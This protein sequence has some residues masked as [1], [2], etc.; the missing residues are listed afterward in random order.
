MALFR[1]VASGAG[2]QCQVR[3]VAAGL[4]AVFCCIETS[5]G[6]SMARLFDTEL[7]RAE[8]NIY[9][10][11]RRPRQMLQ[12]QTYDGHVSIHDESQARELGFSGAPIEGRSAPV[13]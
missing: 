13:A 10:P 1:I 4:F 9:G 12:E 8:G 2:E 7:R 3:L 6:D 5:G 11:Y